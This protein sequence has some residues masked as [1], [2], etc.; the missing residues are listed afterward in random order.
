[1]QEI[2]CSGHVHLRQS[3]FAPPCTPEIEEQRVW[4][5]SAGERFDIMKQFVSYGL[6]HWGSDDKGLETTRRFLLEWM[7]FTHR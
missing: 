7:S 4:D 1:M 2:T 6:E 3:Q 5:I